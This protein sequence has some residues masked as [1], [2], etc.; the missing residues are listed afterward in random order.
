MCFR[1]QRRYVHSA[2][3]NRSWLSVLHTRFRYPYG[4]PC[5]AHE[6]FT[7]RTAYDTGRSETVLDCFRFRHVSL[8]SRAPYTRPEQGQAGLLLLLHFFR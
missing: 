2:T 7:P 6:L 3:H 4:L 8:V 5:S 1:A